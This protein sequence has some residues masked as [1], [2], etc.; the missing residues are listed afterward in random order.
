[1]SKAKYK[2]VCAWYTKDRQ[3]TGRD[4]PTVH[5]VNQKSLSGPDLAC[6][7]RSKASF[8]T[9]RAA[10][11]A[12]VKHDEEHGPLCQLHHHKVEKHFTYVIRVT[13]DAQV[14]HGMK[15]EM[16]ESR[17]LGLAQNLL[18]YDRFNQLPRPLK[19]MAFQAPP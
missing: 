6:C 12:A 17:N 4:L 10:A 13:H 1:M 16:G 8:K 9:P 14:S 3:A 15:L 18:D 5:E 11:L 7:A 19:G 2:W